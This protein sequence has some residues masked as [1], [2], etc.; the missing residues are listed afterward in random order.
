V[1]LL[2]DNYDSFTYNLV[3]Y[4]RQL[5]LEVVVKR[6]DEPFEEIVSETYQ[7]VVLSPGPE[8]PQKAGQLMA[9]TKYYLGKCPV[10]GICLG[11]QALGIHYGAQLVKAIRP[12]HGK[13]SS[14]QHSGTG[15]FGQ[16]PSK[17]AVVRYHSLVLAEVPKGFVATA[18]TSEGE[19]MAMENVNLMAC[20]VQFHPEAILTEYGLQMLRNWVRFY[21]I[22]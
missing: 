16:L 12:M 10:L 9:L 20:G 21:N 2:I 11:H 6:N 19:L 18:R 8:K 3:D 17:L 1:I 15:L 13:I 22:V 4:F 14:I 7:A 5:G